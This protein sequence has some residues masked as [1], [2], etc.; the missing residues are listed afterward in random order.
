[1]KL[2]LVFVAIFLWGAW[3]FL[4]KISES[5][6][7]LQVAFWSSLSFFLV[8]LLYLFLSN[9]LFPLKNDSQGIFFGVLTGLSSGLAAIVFYIL[10]A[11]N[12]AGYLTAATALYPLITIVLSVI[13]LKEGLY[14]TKIVGFILALLALLFLHL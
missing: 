5:K 9:S 7:G 6:I 8:I 14:T 2:L 4:G 11:K 10:L 13:F 3:G 12:P 1:M